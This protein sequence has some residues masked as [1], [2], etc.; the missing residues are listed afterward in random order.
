MIV[1]GRLHGHPSA[2]S[3]SGATDLAAWQICPTSEEAHTGRGWIP[4]QSPFPGGTL[5]PYGANELTLVDGDRRVRVDASFLE[6]TSEGTSAFHSREQQLPRT[7]AAGE[8]P[9]CTIAQGT[10]VEISGCMHDN[11]ILPCDDGCDIVAAGRIVG[12]ERVT[13]F[14]RVAVCRRRHSPI[15][16]VF[17]LGLALSSAAVLATRGRRIRGRG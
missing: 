12:A 1:S 16:L 8:V 4:R 17:S 15:L 6:D 2:T 11:L 14:S 10:V 3:P 7:S 13:A 5:R 9:E